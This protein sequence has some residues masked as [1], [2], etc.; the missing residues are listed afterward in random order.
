MAVSTV[1]QAKTGLIPGKTKTKVV[2]V[3]LSGTYT[4]EGEVLTAAKLG[5]RRIVSATASLTGS[6]ATEAT[7]VGNCFTTIESSGTKVKLRLLNTKTGA[8]LAA[9]VTVVGVKAEVLILGY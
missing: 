7:P 3:A 9:G 1:S 6:N 5:F 8:E 2:T 4:S